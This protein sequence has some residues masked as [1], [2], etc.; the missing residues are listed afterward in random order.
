MLQLTSF[1][2]LILFSYI[3]SWF[4]HNHTLVFTRV[5]SQGCTLS[6]TVKCTSKGI[7]LLHKDYKAP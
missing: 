7:I 3:L 1:L 2:V 6:K 4:Y 5:T